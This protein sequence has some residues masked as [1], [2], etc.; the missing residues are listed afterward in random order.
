M[1]KEESKEVKIDKVLANKLL[2]KLTNLFYDDVKSMCDMAGYHLA[3]LMPKSKES[4]IEKGSPSDIENIRFLHHEENRLAKIMK[5]AQDI[6]SSPEIS[7][8]RSQSTISLMKQLGISV[9]SHRKNSRTSSVSGID[10]FKTFKFQ[11]ELIF[12][13]VSNN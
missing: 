9:V 11:P 5:I 7:L 1:D 3:D 4:F 6:A 13:Q 8:Y 12:L 10:N 2:K